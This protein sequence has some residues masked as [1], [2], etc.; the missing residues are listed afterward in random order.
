MNLYFKSTDLER[1]VPSNSNL[2]KPCL[3]NIPFC[4]AQII[5]TIVENANIRT[6]RLSELK[7]S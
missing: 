4:L 1:Y 7:Q 2:A 3:N 5:C 6:A